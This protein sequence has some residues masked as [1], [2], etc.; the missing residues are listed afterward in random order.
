[1]VLTCAGMGLY[2]PPWGWFG[3]VTAT[4]L[5]SLGEIVG[6]SAMSLVYPARAGPAGHRATYLGAATA[7]YGLGFAVGPALGIAVWNGLGA[8]VWWCCGAAG[9]LCVPLAWY[10]VRS[11]RSAA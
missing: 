2:A 4:L 10:G 6:A 9:L 3:F 11:D 5:W 7:T 8:G 1:M